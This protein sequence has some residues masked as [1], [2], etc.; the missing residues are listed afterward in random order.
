MR[1]IAAL[2]PVKK[3]SDKALAWTQ[4]VTGRWDVPNDEWVPED[5]RN[6]TPI[7]PYTRDRVPTA[8]LYLQ[9]DT[10]ERSGY[11]PAAI[12]ISALM[13]VAVLVLS[14]LPF[15]AKQATSMM[16]LIPALCIGV[17][18]L[19]IAAFTTWMLAQNALRV[20]QI[21]KTLIFG[22]GLP[23]YGL[24]ISSGMMGNAAMWQMK[25]MMLVNILGIAAFAMFIVSFFTPYAKRPRDILFKGIA[26]LALLAVV[27]MFAPSLAFPLTILFSV[28]APR[29][30]YREERR[31]RANQLQAQG[32]YFGGQ[33]T[34]ANMEAHIPRRY[35]QA[36]NGSND[37]SP[38]IVIG[39]SLGVLVERGDTQAYDA[40]Q[41][42]VMSYGR[43]MSTSLIIEGDTGTG[44]SERALIPLTV[45]MM[46][47]QECG[48]VCVMD[49]KSNGAEA[50][51]ANPNYTLVTPTQY[52]TETG[53]VV[54]KG[55]LIN[56]IKNV[57]AGLV[58]EIISMVIKGKEDGDNQDAFFKEHGLTLGYNAEVLLNWVLLTEKHMKENNYAS[59]ATQGWNWCITDLMKAVLQISDTK[60]INNN[61][62]PEVLS[63]IEMLNEFCPLPPSRNPVLNE[64][65][66]YI[67]ESIPLIAASD[68]TW[69]G[70]VST[71]LGYFQPFM[72]NRDLLE[73][74]SCSEGEFDVNSILHGAHMGIYMPS[75]YGQAGTAYQL[76]IHL[77][78]LFEGRAR[79][80][81]WREKDPTAT[82]FCFVIDEFPILAT[83]WDIESLATVR[84]QGG[85][86][87]VATQSR[88]SLIEALQKNATDLLYA[89]ISS[90]ITFRCDVI[91]FEEHAK[92]AGTTKRTPAGG[93][94]I[95][96]NHHSTLRK[97]ANNPA[98]DWNSGAG[99]KDMER[100]ASMNYGVTAGGSNSMKDYDENVKYFNDSN[101]FVKY[102]IGQGMEERPLLTSSDF[103]DLTRG[104]GYAFVSV[105]RGGSVRR[106]FCRLEPMKIKDI[107]PEW[108]PKKKTIDLVK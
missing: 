78:Q 51:V 89:N 91:T 69:G 84:D 70:V 3:M 98:N 104:G 32:T 23:F 29:S 82:E 99:A 41:Q 37:K 52:D 27:A 62:V 1:K 80:T 77:Q 74:A 87:I 42:V 6:Q 26:A 34:G 12:L 10:A 75:K 38:K 20:G 105:M 40:N 60:G 25:M 7:L 79:P 88:A 76:L 107:K 50:F 43:D 19:A 47:N 95:K 71:T 66:S 22:L 17:L 11:N 85:R 21:I 8:G 31:S 108:F 30:I 58:T 90:S 4:Y 96:I 13:P 57:P 54:R 14:L 68:K 18:S 103:H 67:T 35:E 101:R 36:V 56:P 15:F 92:K 44:K 28:Y 72:K 59:Q 63:I 46:V 83:H 33:T 100:L 97:M 94:A 48:G 53:D 49:G 65:I 102:D 24:V 86:Y 9:N 73:W 2:L 39:K 55:V 81:N 64:C 61:G 45:Q 5:L 93:S 106:D 16:E